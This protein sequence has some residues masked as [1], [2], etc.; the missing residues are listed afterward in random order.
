L[1]FAHGRSQFFI[2][3]NVVVRRVLLWTQGLSKI[4]Y[5][6]ILK[7][8]RDLAIG[9]RDLSVSEN[10][11]CFF[12]CSLMWI[13]GYKQYTPNPSCSL[14]RGADHLFKASSFHLPDK[15]TRGVVW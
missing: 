14:L 8:F 3:L 12:Q 5:I 7:G 2:E 4:V 9:F 6:Q 10:P 11:S 13:L 15:K 1:S